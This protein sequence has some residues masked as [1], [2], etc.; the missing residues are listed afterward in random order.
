MGPACQQ[1]DRAAGPACDARGLGS[2][3]SAQQHEVSDAVPCPVGSVPVTQSERNCTMLG[4]RR[5][6]S[7][8]A[9]YR[10]HKQNGAV[11]TRA[12]FRPRYAWVHIMILYALLSLEAA[13]YVPSHN[14]PNLTIVV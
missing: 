13:W 6:R 14:L 3:S 12:D 2:T 8:A 4:C 11:W 1:S 9:S 7:N 10:G 5:R